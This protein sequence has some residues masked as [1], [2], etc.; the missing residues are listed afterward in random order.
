MRVVEGKLITYV[1]L[2]CKDGIRGGSLFVGVRWMKKLMPPDI[3]DLYPT[4]PPLTKGRDKNETPSHPQAHFRP[5]KDEESQ[6]G[7][8][9]QQIS[10]TGIYHGKFGRSLFVFKLNEFQETIFG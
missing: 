4:F 6:F 10:G 2:L 9:W 5:Y 7:S 3:S 1:P 8:F